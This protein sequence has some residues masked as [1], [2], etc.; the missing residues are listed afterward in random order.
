[1]TDAA[2][3]EA[4]E[5]EGYGAPVEALV[6][7][8]DIEAFCATSAM[9]TALQEAAYDRRM[10]RTSI[11]VAM[12]GVGKAVDTYEESETPHLLIIE[13]EKS[14]LAVFEDLER[15]AEVCDPD[16][17]V[18]VCGPSNDVT[19]YR[20][21]KRQGVDEYI[22]SPA[23]TM[24]IIEAVAT[25]F[26]DP[27][28][29]PMARTVGVFGVK[30][31]CG[32]STIA[33]N[34][35]WM[36]GQS[37]KKEV[38]LVDLDV[39]F[40]TAG[41]DFACEPTRTV[42]DAFGAPDEL[43]DV[44]LQRLLVEHDE[45]LS[46]LGAPASLEIEADFEEPGVVEAVQLIQ[47]SS[48][49]AVFDIP[50][51][52]N[53]WTQ[54]TMTQVENLVIVATP[55]LASVRNLKSFCDLIKLRRPNDAPPI[56]V[57]N[58]VGMTKRPEVATSDIED[59]LGRPVDFEIPFDPH[60]FGLAANDGKM[61]QESNA[62]HP[63]VALMSE[64]CDRLVAR[65]GVAKKSAASGSKKASSVIAKLKSF[66]LSSLKSRFKQSKKSEA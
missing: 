33:H 4:F 62:K 20:E 32:S 38:M 11:A 45:Y 50:H 57:L 12:G 16:T 52:W 44:K 24:Q 66:D 51:I 64:I 55:E 27:A 10:A 60:A 14:G 17:K 18:I 56:I 48:D 21:L 63:A 15:L 6:P 23:A 8:I 59:V 34:I 1:M 37:E 9:A 19:L 30:G 58:T 5:D 43:D 40:G 3:N 22:I 2:H 35:A 47:Q 26:S 54:R 41:L 28:A 36:L 53:R 42:V 31:G 7:R 29:A 39:S 13:T 25:V 61:L 46:I 65:P 49:Y